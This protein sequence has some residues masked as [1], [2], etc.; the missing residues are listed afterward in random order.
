[1]GNILNALANG[2]WLKDIHGWRIN[3]AHVVFFK[4]EVDE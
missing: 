1:M 2:E 4:E 3:P